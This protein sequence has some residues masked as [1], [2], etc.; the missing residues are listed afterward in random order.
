MPLN[1]TSGTS[2][3]IFPIDHPSLPAG[4]PSNEYKHHTMKSTITGAIQEISIIESN[5]G[6]SFEI[7]L[8]I[9]PTAYAALHQ[10]DGSSG[11]RHLQEDDYLIYVLLDGINAQRS[12]RHRSQRAPTRI[13]GAYSRDRTS[14]RS[15]QFGALNLVDPDD[16]Q[17]PSAQNL[18]G[19][20]CQDEKIIQALGTIQVNIVRCTLGA[21]QPVPRRPY[22]VSNSRNS[23]PASETLQT[24]NQMMFSERSKK[25]C[26]LNTVGLGQ[27]VNT[28][29]PGRG[30]GGVPMPGKKSIRPVVHEEKHPFLQFIFKYKPRTILEAEGIIAQP[31]PPPPSPP[32]QPSAG[33][34]KSAAKSS[35]MK[36]GLSD[37][38]RLGH[39]FQSNAELHKSSLNPNAHLTNDSDEKKPKVQEKPMYIDIDSDSDSEYVA[40][41]VRGEGTSL[42]SSTSQAQRP[43]AK[44]EPRDHDDP[45]WAQVTQGHSQS[46]VPADFKK[47]GRSPTADVKPHKRVS[48]GDLSNNAAVLSAS[49][50]RDIP[51]T[52]L[53]ASMNAHHPTRT[54]AATAGT[55]NNGANQSSHAS[56]Y[57]DEGS[58]DDDKFKSTILAP[59]TI[60]TALTSQL[61]PV[62]QSSKKPSPQ[63]LNR[64]NNTIH[65]S[66]RNK[67]LP[68]QGP[69]FFDLTG[70]DDDSD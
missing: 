64:L 13:S 70:M 48:L 29:L 44:R 50:S 22:R 7:S 12:K 27:P 30:R 19:Q 34:L 56:P 25:A 20:I 53:K 40:K 42:H 3:S 62:H 26:M 35:S 2:C 32:R 69:N 17:Q 63:T 43:H 6:T 24:T 61:N 31:P 11:H 21:P 67:S 41:H 1:E 8:D 55:T 66:R 37:Q 52:E 57:L 18:N 46:R 47:R 38:A 14:S 36:P 68:S 15:F 45:V 23:H 59:G 5:Q 60:P 39:D 49:A 9:K 54:A 33:N 10:A 4:L 28:C 65:H 51:K 58:D 16:F